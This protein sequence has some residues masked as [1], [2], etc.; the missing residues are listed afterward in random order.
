MATLLTRSFA[1]MELREDGRTVFG[2]IVPYGEVAQVF[3]L[4]GEPYNEVFV[5]GAFEGAMKVPERIDLRY[6]HSGSFDNVLGQASN[7]EERDDGLYGTFRL[8]ESVSTRAR[9]VLQ[10]HA[11]HLSVGFFPIKSRKRQGV[12]ERVKAYLEHVAATATPAY[13]GAGVLA[14]RE[15]VVTEE[16]EHPGETPNLDQVQRYLEEVR[17]KFD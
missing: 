11:K 10:G 2:R 7:L 13:A 5:R 1:A 4:S 14:I 17:R 12:V 15:D 16:R 3:D 6:S 8:Y 9:E